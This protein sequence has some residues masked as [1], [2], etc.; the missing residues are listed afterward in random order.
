MP[1]PPPLG[2]LQRKA[3]A[4]AGFD[5]DPVADAGWWRLGISGVPGTC[6]VASGDRGT[7]IA[8]SLAEQ[9]DELV[10]AHGGGLPL[11][12]VSAAV[13]DALPAAPAGATGA[14]HC[15]TE[16]SLL[17][18]LQR[19]RALLLAAPMRLMARVEERSARVGTTE[20]LAEVRR[21][22]GQDLY[23]EALLGYWNSACA[24]TGL[25]VPELLRASHAKPWKDSSDRERLD[26]YNGVLLAPHLD[27]VFDSGFATFADDGRL[28]F[29][30]QLTI[31]ARASLGLTAGEP[32]LRWVA[33]QHLPYL[34]WHR[35]KVFRSTPAT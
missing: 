5:L 8:L 3:I 12:E 6:W 24:V 34:K 20:A 11:S 22:I 31:E 2:T 35:T 27:L 30:D 18:A 25:R 32:R 4:D 29:S 15:P 21:R 7:A 9:H 14:L 19:I 13:R 23:R 33:P 17:G 10:T 1:T 28:Q 26:V 16:G